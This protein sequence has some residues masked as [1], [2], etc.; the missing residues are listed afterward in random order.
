MP[1]IAVKENFYIELVITP[2]TANLINRNE[3]C[4]QTRMLNMN[5]NRQLD[6]NILLT[7]NLLDFFLT[8][9]SD[10]LFETS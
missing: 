4:I 6:W 5:I 10:F 1:Y 8:N 7:T 2:L 9:H 3:I